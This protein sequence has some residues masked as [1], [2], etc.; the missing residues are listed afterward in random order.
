M[1]EWERGV[2]GDAGGGCMRECLDYSPWNNGQTAFVGSMICDHMILGSEETPI[3]IETE[4]NPASH[5]ERWD[6]H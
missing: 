1:S 4:C 3:E 6:Q 2:R 5:Y